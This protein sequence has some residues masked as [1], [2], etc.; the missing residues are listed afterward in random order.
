MR[1]FSSPLTVCW[2]CFN[3]GAKPVH[4]CGPPAKVLLWVLVCL[5]AGSLGGVWASLN[6]SQRNS[7]EIAED[8]AAA[9]TGVHSSV[10]GSTG[11]LGSSRDARGSNGSSGGG[12]DAAATQAQL[13]MEL[14]KSRFFGGEASL[15]QLGID[16]SSSSSSYTASG[17]V[18]HE[19]QQQE[20]SGY[21]SSKTS[22][23]PQ[24]EAYSSSL[25]QQHSSSSTTSRG[26]PL[27]L[28][29]GPNAQQ[30]AMAAA[31]TG[32]ESGR[33]SALGSASALGSGHRGPD[34]WHHPAQAESALQPA[35]SS[36]SSCGGG[37]R[38][39]AAAAGSG[40]WPQQLEGAADCNAALGSSGGFGFEVAAGQLHHS[41]CHELF[42][43]CGDAVCLQHAFLHFTPLT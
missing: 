25:V 17:Y 19:Q 18:Q 13:K 39:L 23:V 29:G 22:G 38:A 41:S 12:S 11:G 10:R 24:H 31:Q 35:G 2:V 9:A 32:A 37:G 28:S 33:S 20:Y 4:C 36:S 14:P 15:E 6:S 30:L 34:N 3:L 40:G 27:L 42:A 7:L 16:C 1:I 21:S 26:Q 8:V 43:D 5:A